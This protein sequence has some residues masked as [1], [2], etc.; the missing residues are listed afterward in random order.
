ME[1]Q[2]SRSE[3]FYEESPSRHADPANSKL[4]VKLVE[5]AQKVTNLQLNENILPK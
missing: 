4:Q 5:F 2:D 3:K 1:S